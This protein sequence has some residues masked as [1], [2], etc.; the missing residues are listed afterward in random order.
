MCRARSNNQR[1]N[2]IN[3][4]MANNN[5][6]N[7][8]DNINNNKVINMVNKMVNKMVKLVAINR[9]IRRRRRQTP[10]RSQPMCAFRGT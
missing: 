10:A 2:Q 1:I 9:V 7:N 6:N 5:N 8:N 4:H 3:I